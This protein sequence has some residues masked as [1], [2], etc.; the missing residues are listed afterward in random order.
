M[1]VKLIAIPHV[2]LLVKLIAKLL[3]RHLAYF[4]MD[5]KFVHLNAKLPV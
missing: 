3:V 4:V 1:A 5:V 2:K